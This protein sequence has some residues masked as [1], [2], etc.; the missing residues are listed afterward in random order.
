MSE[1]LAT[2]ELFAL[3][4]CHPRWPYSCTSWILLLFTTHHRMTYLFTHHRHFLYT[5]Y[6]TILKKFR[7]AAFVEQHA[8]ADAHGFEV[9]AGGEVAHARPR[10]ATVAQQIGIGIGRGFGLHEPVL[11]CHGR[12]GLVRSIAMDATATEKAKARRVQWFLYGLVVVMV[13][14]PLIVFFLRHT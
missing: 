10:G 7:P 11:H 1:L 9:K 14:A 8:I 5:H 3:F 2:S 6:L 13:G 12:R 4:H